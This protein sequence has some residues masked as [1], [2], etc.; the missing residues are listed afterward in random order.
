VVTRKYSHL[1]S[2]SLSQPCFFGAVHT[3]EAERQVRD[4]LIGPRN[5]KQ[6]KIIHRSKLQAGTSD[7]DGHKESQLIGAA[8]RPRP[9][10]ACSGQ[11]ALQKRRGCSGSC[12]LERW[13]KNFNDRPF[14]SLFFYCVRKSR[15]WRSA[16]RVD[17][18][19]RS[20]PNLKFFLT[21]GRMTSP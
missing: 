17:F 14:F 10:S 3:L 20:G 8:T 1:T 18:P 16:S 5:K 15:T 11:L 2:S 12:N 7:D 6:R 21:S 13:M 9:T 4:F 19:R